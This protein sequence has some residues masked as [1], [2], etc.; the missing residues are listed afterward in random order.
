MELEG[1][2][3]YGLVWKRQQGG[4]GRGRL[5]AKGIHTYVADYETRVQW[6]KRLRKTR[7]NLLPGYALIHTCIDPGVYLKVLQTNS[8]VKFVGNAWPGVSS[9]PDEEVESLQLLLG[10]RQHIHDVPY[11]HKGAKVE[12]IGVALAGKVGKVDA[13]ENGKRRGMV[14]MD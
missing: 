10:A 8:V 7:K 3:R 14:A 13:G 9:I 6:G 11:W 5:L 1:S 12:V 2:Q 4:G